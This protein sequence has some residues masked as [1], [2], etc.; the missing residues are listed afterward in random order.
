MRL[1]LLFCCLFVLLLLA[2]VCVWQR[3]HAGCRNKPILNKPILTH[4][5]T[6]QS[7]LHQIHHQRTQKRESERVRIEANNPN[8]KMPMVRYIGGTWRVGGLLALSRAFG[9][10]Y[11]KG[12]LQFE[13]VGA[14]GFNNYSSGFGLVAEPYTVDVELTG[15]CAGWGRGWG[16]GFQVWLLVALAVEAIKV[17]ARVQTQSTQR[18]NTNTNTNTNIPTQHQHHRAAADTHVVIASDGLFAEEARGVGGGLDNA[19]VAE[20]C[21]TG[22]S[23][24]ELAK[25]MSLAAQKV[26]STDDVT[27]VVLRLG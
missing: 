11:L 9:D 25:T 22:A 12:S 15:A 14:G 26:G 20:L 6:N 16:G 1:L 3:A 10:A 18:H 7:P 5:L 17:C 23:C 21:Q 24:A 13:G 2:A 4:T 19:A 8:P 27:V